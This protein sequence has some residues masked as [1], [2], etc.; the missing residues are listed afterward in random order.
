MPMTGA[1]STG[2][3]DW[4]SIDW[5]KVNQHVH[6]LQM[7]IAKA[8]RENRQGKVQSLQWILTHSF[9][10]KL[11]ATRQ[12]TRNRGRKTAGVDNIFLRTPKQKMHM[13]ASL[14]RRGYR[15]KPLRRI[16]I[17]KK[18]GK[19]RPLGI[20]TMKDRSMQA[21]YLLALEPISEVSADKN[22][23]G[24]RPKRSA[25]DAIEQCFK[26]LSHK[27]STQWIL[28]ADIKACFD[29]INHQWLLEHIPIDKMILKQWLTAGF[30]ENQ[31]LMPTMEG[32]PQGGI[33]SPT[34]ANVTLDGLEKLIKSFSNRKV[35]V[36][37][38]R[39]A[40]DFIITGSSKE[41]LENK[42]KPA[43]ERFL[44]ERG[45]ELSQEKTKITHI[46]DGFN[47]LGFNIR[48]YQNGKLLIKPTNDS[49]LKLLR[50]IRA[51]I[52][53][54]KGA[55]SEQL[56]SQLNPKL[57]G[58]AYYYR[59]VVSKDIFSKIDNN[60]FLAT[61]AW[62]SRRHSNKSRSWRKKKYFRSEG[63]RNW[64]FSTEISDAYGNPEHLDLFRLSD[65]A[66]KRHRK[67]IAEATPFDMKYK[68]YFEQRELHRKKADYQYH[69]EVVKLEYMLT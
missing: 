24:F 62:I 45:L 64:I 11:A 26:V 35:R 17:P 46:R 21:L 42:I 63:L 34:L 53:Q 25:A 3:T 44:H 13:A 6:R 19:L 7:R 43:V 28:E 16:Y 50:D 68:E 8:I 27:Q 69:K 23:Y 61:Y 48:K 57:R 39:Y 14:K 22:S 4:D 33:I 41:L 37:L 36:N 60:I 10:A 2:R 15:A 54:N 1:S 58:W 67:I 52:K 65:L 32:T 29:K 40:D 49:V 12:V 30:I 55:N 31:A 47:F 59:H 51:V 20:P 38:V 18:N 66:I 56:I 9:Y 5:E